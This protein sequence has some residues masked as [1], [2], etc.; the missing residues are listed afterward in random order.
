MGAMLYLSIQSP[1]KYGSQA[2]KKICKLPQAKCFGQ[3]DRK[4]ARYFSNQRKCTSTTE[5]SFFVHLLQNLLGTAS[6]EISLLF[7]PFS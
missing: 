2:Q 1:K 5:W 7:L 4:E 6:L 3:E